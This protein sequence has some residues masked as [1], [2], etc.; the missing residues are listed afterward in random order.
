MSRFAKPDGS[1]EHIGDAGLEMILR[2]EVKVIDSFDKRIGGP[3]A[4][5]RT[6]TNAAKIGSDVV[7]V[8]TGKVGELYY[9]ILNR[10]AIIAREIR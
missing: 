7:K 5:K 3:A 2:P 6:S 9:I 10:S 8:P 4:G 1:Q